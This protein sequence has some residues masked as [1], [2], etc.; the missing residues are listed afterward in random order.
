MNDL[1]AARG[2]VKKGQEIFLTVQKCGGVF[3]SAKSKKQDCR[4]VFER[5][6]FCFL[7]INRIEKFLSRKR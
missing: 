4:I 3:R 2:I 5:F 7:K 6:G 1:A